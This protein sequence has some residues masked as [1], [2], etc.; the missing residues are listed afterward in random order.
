MQTGLNGS[1]LTDLTLDGQ[2]PG[3]SF[4]SFG[5]RTAQVLTQVLVSGALISQLLFLSDQQVPVWAMNPIPVVL[6]HF[7]D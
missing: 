6:S 4:A 5:A 7:P 3:Q 2:L 1:W